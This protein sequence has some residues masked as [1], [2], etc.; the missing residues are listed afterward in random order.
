MPPHH[1]VQHVVK[2]HRP[3]WG[4]SLLSAIAAVRVVQWRFKGMIWLSLYFCVQFL[5]F[6]S[7]Q[8]F[9]NR[10][11]LA[12]KQPQSFPVAP[13]FDGKQQAAG[14]LPRALRLLK[15]RARRLS[16]VSFPNSRTAGHH[17]EQPGEFTSR[18]TARTCCWRQRPGLLGLRRGQQGRQLPPRGETSYFPSQY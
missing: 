14:G 6:F 4:N 3:G 2:G 11:S 17:P 10:T 15:C 16:L 8:L 7:R 12:W 13:A 18:G 1:P 5:A 9:C